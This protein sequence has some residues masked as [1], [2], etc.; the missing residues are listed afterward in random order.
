MFVTPFQALG[1]GPGRVEEEKE[2]GRRALMNPW[3]KTPGMGS[4]FQTAAFPPLS[5]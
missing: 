1:G 3:K 4:E 5:T 2:E